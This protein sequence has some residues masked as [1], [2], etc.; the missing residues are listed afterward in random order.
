M[1]GHIVHLGLLHWAKD[2]KVS[3][4]DVIFSL[5]TLRHAADFNPNDM[6]LLFSSIE[7]LKANDT[8]QLNPLDPEQNRL[9]RQADLF[10][11][12][13][14]G[15]AA[16]LDCID[17]LAGI[18]RIIQIMFK[19]TL[20]ALRDRFAFFGQEALRIQG[21][22]SKGLQMLQLG[23]TSL[24]SRSLQIGEE[25]TVDA[26]IARFETERQNLQRDLAAIA[27]ME[28]QFGN[29]SLLPTEL[30]CSR[31]SLEAAQLTLDA[32][33]RD[34]QEFA[35]IVGGATAVREKMGELLKLMRFPEDT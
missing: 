13:T 5:L 16:M 27:A 29:R 20:S 21:I 7:H 1:A 12:D 15:P 11:R 3:N 32:R 26:M 31:A 33:L 14:V 25:E 18:Y 9:A 23:L 28:A 30:K 8:F 34:L 2:L 4:T 35:R 17:S 19:A 22:S 6:A 24:A 10:T